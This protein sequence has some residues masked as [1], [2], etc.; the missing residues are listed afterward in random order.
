MPYDTEDLGLSERQKELKKWN[1]PYRYQEF[2]KTLFRGVSTTAGHPEYRLVAS[3]REE[4]EA[5]AGGWSL[6]PDAAVNRQRLAEEAVGI[7]AAERA[8]TDRQMSVAAQREAA[9]AEAT[10]AGHVAEV[11]AQPVRKRKSR[12]KPKPPRVDP[13][14]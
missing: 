10:T 4:A 2:P 11:R 14:A 12:A 9:A 1:A 13:G 6:T 3:D 5:L 7:A 8:Y